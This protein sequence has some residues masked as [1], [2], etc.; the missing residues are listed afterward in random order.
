MRPIWFDREGDTESYEK[1]WEDTEFILGKSIL[2]APVLQEGATKREVNQLLSFLSLSLTNLCI[3]I[4]T[5]WKP[6][7]QFLHKEDRG[8][9]TSGDCGRTAQRTSVVRC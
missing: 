8:G 6:L 7:G 3:G 2:V 9:R 4:P 1:K 5:I